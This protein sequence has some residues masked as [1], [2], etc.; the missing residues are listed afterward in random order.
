MARGHDRIKNARTSLSKRQGRPTQEQMADLVLVLA[1]IRRSR[2]AAEVFGDEA[3]HRFTT[4]IGIPKF[5]KR[6]AAVGRVVAA[7]DVWVLRPTEAALLSR[8]VQIEADRGAG[9]K[10]R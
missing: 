7:T 6:Q 5:G 8:A 2:A 4:N 1:R 9:P 3:L 10:V